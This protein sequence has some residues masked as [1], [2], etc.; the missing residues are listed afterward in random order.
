MVAWTE[1]LLALAGERRLWEGR[2]QFG[3]WLDPDAPPDRPAAAKTDPDVVA[4]AYLYRS[5]DL[6][7]RA[8]ALLGRDDDAARLRAVAEEIRAAFLAEYVTPAGR[9]VS[10]AQTAYA[11][12]IMFE[13]APPEQR[14]RLG[15]RLAQLVRQSGYRIGTG[16]VGTPIV[17]DALTRTGHLDVAA[18]LLT[19]TECPS[20]LYPVTMGATTI[21]ERWDSMLPDGS[22]NPG[23]MT[24]FNHYALGAIADWLHRV[25]AGLGP[26]EPGYRRLVVAPHPLPGFDHA[27]A[28][29]RTPYGTA[30]VG[31]RRLPGG[32]VEV[33]A[34]VPPN[35]RAEV[36]LPG[37]DDR[38]TV[39]S[40][41]HRWTVADPTPA[42]VR[43][44]L[45]ADPALA[46]VVDDP[47]AYAALL[48]VLSDLH[49][50]VAEDVRARTVWLPGRTVDE[51]LQARAP[52]DVRRH[53]AERFAA[54][55]ERRVAGHA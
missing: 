26:A 41:E 27:E 3:D 31:W 29:H 50:D 32:Q 7:A 15:D 11:L 39:G 44:P 17:C 30:T 46:T 55:D 23:E 52:Q 22:I 35:T 51:V 37:R 1:S 12:A 2:F 18:R 49:P 5:T 8:A 10:D 19:Q 40:G 14:V 28:T 43:P 4:S 25:V 36:R 54:I 53:V 33:H 42:P 13:I 47:E 48:D 20:W 24:S 45:G 34:S 38:P 6:T 9:M 21:W 16:F